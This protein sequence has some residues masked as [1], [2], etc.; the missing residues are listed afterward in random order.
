VQLLI[1]DFFAAASLAQNAFWEFSPYI[2]LMGSR[3]SMRTCFILEKYFERLSC[4]S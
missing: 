2:G 3:D 4:S 1:A